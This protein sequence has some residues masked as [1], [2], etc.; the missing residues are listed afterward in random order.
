MRNRASSLETIVR[1]PSISHQK[2]YG[3]CVNESERLALYHQESDFLFDGFCLFPTKDIARRDRTPGNQRSLRLSRAEKLLPKT[4]PWVRRIDLISIRSALESIG[5]RRVVIIENERIPDYWIGVLVAI[6]KTS[7][8]IRHFDML[9]KWM[10]VFNIPYR[11]I[12]V[13][14]VH[15]RYQRIHAKYLGTG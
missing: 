12:T 3:I 13:I 9:G 7:C 5:T 6:G 1:R 8:R 15:S 14:K 2:F 11:Q 4:P 10:G